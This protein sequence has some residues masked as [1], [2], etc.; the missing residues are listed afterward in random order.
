LPHDLFSMSKTFTSCAVGFARAEGLLDLEDRVVDHLGD[1]GSTDPNLHAMRLRHLL[2]MTTGHDGDVTGQTVTDP[3]WVHGFLS[4]PVQHP[5]GTHFVYNT[6]ATY[7]LSAVVQART[8]QRLLDYL[9]P[10][11]LE[12]LGVAGA[13]WEQSPQ[14]IDTGGFGLALRTEDIACFGQLLLQDGVWQGRQV[15]PEGWVAE[16]SAR[17]VRSVHSESDWTE[18]YG[19]QLW[20]SRHGYRADG[21]FGQ[22]CLVLPEHQAVVVMTSATPDLQGVL[23]RVWEHLVPHLD[24]PGPAP[25]DLAV[26][27]PGPV[28]AD[29]LAGALAPGL[30][31]RTFDLDPNPLGLTAMRLDAPDGGDGLEW[32]LWDRDG[33]GTIDVGPGRWVASTVGLRL[34]REGPVTGPVEV[35]GAAALPD[36]GRLVLHVRPTVG[37]SRFEAQITWSDA[38]VQM[39][40]GVN[41]AFG[42]TDLG[43]LTGHART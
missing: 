37:P 17:Q 7:A 16:A 41:V 35:V 10:R 29:P 36:P 27:L 14:G 21:A 28:P 38:T 31:G 24:D 43:T 3:D 5:P 25:G 26:L 30:L 18:G 42:P 23:N 15:L 19:Y 11:L 1:A 34:G 39:A 8:G 4:Q 22:F 6:A 40:L 33:E 2:T 32:T 20:R 12:P 13:T 9:T